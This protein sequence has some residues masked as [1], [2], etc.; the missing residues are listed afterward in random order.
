MLHAQGNFR[1]DGSFSDATGD[2]GNSGQI[3]T[4]TAA[5][6]NWIDMPSGADNL[7]D[8]TA[9]QHLNMGTAFSIQANGD[10]GS[11]GQVLTRSATGNGMTWT[12]PSS[13]T[14]VQTLTSTA[15]IGDGMGLVLLN[16]SAD[17]TVTMP[18]ANSATYPEGTILHIRRM[19]AHTGTADSITLS[20]GTG[21]PVSRQIEGEN[22][23]LMNIGYQSNSFVATTTG[24]MV[25]K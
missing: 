16:P 15:S 20:S 4:S 12:S 13:T 5:G 3:L 22:T 17:M 25:M 11:A 19:G 2:A 24:W 14:T 7:G 8:H 6:T 21:T 9:T 10:T 1:L 18:E 23:R